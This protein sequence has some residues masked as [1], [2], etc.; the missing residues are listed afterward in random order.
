M[1]NENIPLSYKGRPLLRKDNLIYYGDMSAPYIVQIQI[2]DTKNMKD[3][4]VASRVSVQ[5][6]RNDSTLK[7]RDLIEKRSEKENLY[8]AIDIAAVWLDRALA[9]R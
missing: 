3:M 1:A 2:L 9:N 5:L 6:Q 7:G 4:K 8:A